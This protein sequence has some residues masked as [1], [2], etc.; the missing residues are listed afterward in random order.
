MGGPDTGIAKGGDK[1]RT[2]ERQSIDGSR[3]WRGGDKTE[4]G[5]GDVSVGGEMQSENQLRSCDGSDEAAAAGQSG[6]TRR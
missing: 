4:E 1:E 6:K 2:E 5:R 3:R